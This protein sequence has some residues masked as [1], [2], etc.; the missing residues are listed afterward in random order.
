MSKITEVF[1]FLLVVKKNVRFP[2]NFR[3]KVDGFDS[4]KLSWVPGKSVVG[5]KLMDDKTKWH[6]RITPQ[7]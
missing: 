2:Y 7:S 1:Y 6:A 4:T 5:P 3:T